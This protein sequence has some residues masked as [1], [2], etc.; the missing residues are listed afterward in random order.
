MRIL[1]VV[2]VLGLSGCGGHYI[3]IP[4]VKDSDPV[5]QLNPDRW[6]ASVNDLTTPPG[7]GSPR[8]LPAPVPLGTDKVPAST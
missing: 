6:S 3:P 4:E 1:A 8:P 7:D 2:L 5:S